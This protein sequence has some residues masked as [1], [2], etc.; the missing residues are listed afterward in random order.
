MYIYLLLSPSPSSI[1]N[2]FNYEIASI[3]AGMQGKFEQVQNDGGKAGSAVKAQLG[4]MLSREQREAVHHDSGP[5]GGVHAG[6][7]HYGD[8]IEGTQAVRPGKVEPHGIV[9]G[10]PPLSPPPG[11]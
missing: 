7:H 11:L 10:G 5:A 6:Y 1:L 8:L 4:A 3:G 2:V 9:D